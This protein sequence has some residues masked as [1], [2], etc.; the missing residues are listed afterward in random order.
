VDDYIKTT[1]SQLL[2]P[3]LGFHF[4][5]EQWNFP[6]DLDI[7]TIEHLDRAKLFA[8]RNIPEP[9]RRGKNAS[10]AIADE[11]E[12]TSKPKPISILKDDSLNIKSA[13]VNLTIKISLWLIHPT[14][15]TTKNFLLEKKLS[16]KKE[17]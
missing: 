10:S 12:E 8:K 11:T 3:L 13:H 5:D 4:A 9:K 1:Q 2:L 15:K 14:T 6:T 16:E 17:I 7:V